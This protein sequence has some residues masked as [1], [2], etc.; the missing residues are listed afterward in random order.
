MQQHIIPRIFEYPSNSNNELDF[1]KI[2]TD[3]ISFT[4]YHF[5]EDID[6]Y[7]NEI[8]MERIEFEK[9][10]KER[11]KKFEEKE[12]ERLAYLHKQ[13]VEF[14]Q[15]YNPWD[16]LGLEQND[17][18]IHR[19]KKAYKKNALKYHPDKAGSKYESRF[20]Q[21]TQSYIYLLGKA[22]EK[23]K[24]Y[25]LQHKKVYHQE[26]EDDINEKVENIYLDKDKFDIHQFNK[27]FDKYKIPSSFDKG[28]HE[29]M[30]ED[31]I[32]E[33]VLFGK[34]CNNDIFNAHFNQLKQKKS[35]DLIRYETPDALYSSL[36][37]LNTTHFGV[38]E[39]E[40]FGSVN[41]NQLSYTDYKKAHIDEPLLINVDQVKYK[42]YQTIDQL[43]QDRSSI[44]YQMTPEDLQ[45]THYMERMKNEEEQQRLSNQRKKDEQIQKQYHT[46]NQRLIIHK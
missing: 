8:Q 42:T 20:Q 26:Y 21:I 15:S 2:K 17:Y 28:Y 13:I 43:E 6:Q 9:S 10:E 36:Q 31:V 5:T 33:D 23:N 14:E 45:R 35:N 12:K 44:S 39:I 38:E 7:K 41:N 29:L 24:I 3:A 22:E 18:D 4:P 1:P 34:K 40:D 25:E 46:I 16:I 30:K 19:I 37:T 27:I 32:K 11:R